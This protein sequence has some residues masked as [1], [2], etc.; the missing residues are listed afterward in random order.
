MS[1]DMDPVTSVFTVVSAPDAS[2][3]PIVLETSTGRLS[4]AADLTPEEFA[5]LDQM[6]RETADFDQDM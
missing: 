1:E 5:I 4:V 3:P 6:R 2:K